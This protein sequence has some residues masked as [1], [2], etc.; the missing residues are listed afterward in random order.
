MIYLDIKNNE[1]VISGIYSITNTDTNNTYIGI[2]KD[3][4][5][6]WDRHIYLLKNDKHHQYNF[7]NEFNEYGVECFDFSILERFNSY[8]EN[9]VKQ[10]ED[11]YILE[12]R[13][14]GTGF[15]QK[16][17]L[18]IGENYIKAVKNKDKK[19]HFYMNIDKVN[20]LNLSSQTF[21]RLLYLVSFMDYKNVIKFGKSKGNNFVTKNDL[22][23]MLNINS[24]KKFEIIKELIDK[25]IIYLENEIFKVNK[26][27]FKRGTIYD[28]DDNYVKIYNDFIKRIYTSTTVKSHKPIGT[29]LKLIPYCHLETNIL[30][31]NPSE[32]VFSNINPLKKSDILKI[33]NRSRKDIEFLSNMIL[34]ADGYGINNAYIF[35][36]DFIYNGND[37]SDIN[38]EVTNKDCK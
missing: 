2:S 22:Y 3:I 10:L 33:L 29:I 24:T 27:I 8:V 20:K 13:K 21:F 7:Q 4:Y 5:S 28:K 19:E 31:F 11:F 38:I 34:R 9:I 14:S 35:N 18:E 25:N 30:C 15:G 26:K 1:E 36:P 12:H 32:K 6:R 37:F 17:N 16:T 23:E